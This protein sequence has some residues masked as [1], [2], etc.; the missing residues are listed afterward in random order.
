MRQLKYQALTNILIL[1][2]FNW[3]KIE[4]QNY[5]DEDHHWMSYGNFGDKEK[6]LIAYLILI[7]NNSMIAMPFL[8]YFLHD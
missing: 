4:L 5:D 6:N 1:Y 2:W 8:L 3:S 7:L